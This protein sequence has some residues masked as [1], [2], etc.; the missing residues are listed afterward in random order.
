MNLVIKRGR[1]HGVGSYNNVRNFCMRHPK[2]GKFYRGKMP[3][4]MNGWRTV[5][6]LYD[7][8]QDIDLYV[9][10]LNEVH[11]QGA[12]VGPTAGCIIAGKVII[13]IFVSCEQQSRIVVDIQTNYIVYIISK[14]GLKM[15]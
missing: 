9:G 6:G 14:K 1:E 5:A 3:E 8:P 15:T 11:M 2:Y 4:M 7:S 13:V 10:V 12:Q